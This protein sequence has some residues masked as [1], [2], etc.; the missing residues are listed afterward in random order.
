MK[1]LIVSDAQS[2]HTKRWIFS[3]SKKGVKIIFFTIKKPNDDFFDIEGVTTYYYDLFSYKNKGK[4]SKVL[5]S[6]LNHFK[7]V[8]MLKEIIKKEKPDILHS[9]YL[10]SYSLIGVLSNFSPFIVSIWGSDIYEFPQK[11]FIN[12]FAVKKILKKA[13]S[14]LST[15]HIMAIEAKKYTN[16]QIQII[17]FGVEIDK[18]KKIEFSVSRQKSTFIVG[19]VKTLSIKYGIDVLIRAFKIVSDN[20]KGI[21]CQLYIVGVGDQYEELNKLV[22]TLS[23]KDRVIFKGFIKNSDLPDIY[24]SFDVAVFL[25]RAESFGVSAVE[26]MSCECPVVVSDADGFTEVVRDNFSGFIVRKNDPKGA[27]QAIQRFIDNRD[28][29]DSIGKNARVTVLNNYSWDNNVNDMMSIYYGY[30]KR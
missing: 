14:I 26:A 16:K 25:S 15:S 6:F 29:I 27:A 28:L 30:T 23:L 11:N 22:E 8:K 19:T 12:K 13:D 5:F 7:A 4:I 10:T 18:F 20:N 21:D 17:P 24:N 3:L 1:V 9:Y 2:V